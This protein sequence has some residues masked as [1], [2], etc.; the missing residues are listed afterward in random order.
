L[1]FPDA[2]IIIKG[3]LIKKLGR[4]EILSELGK[5]SM[6]IV[7]K[8]VDPLIDRTVAIKTINL[9][10]SGDEIVGFVERFNREAKS[11]GRLNHPNIVTIYDVGKTDDTAYI[12]ME[13]LE[14]QELKE[15]IASRQTL[16]PERI[17]EITAQIADGLAFAHDNG[18]VHRDIKPANIMILRNDVVKIMDFGIAM[19]S[20]GSQTIAGTI[21]G[22]PKY[23]SPEQVSGIAVDGRSDIFSLGA[24]LYEMLTG[25]SVFG[26]GS[27]N[28]LTS[29]MYQVVNEMPELPTKVNPA[30]PTA[31]DYIVSKAMAK[32]QED[33]Y[34]SAREM[35]DDLRSFMKLIIP[36]PLPSPVLSG[37]R[38]VANSQKN[39]DATLFLGPIRKTPVI[40]GW[41]L[42]KKR[43]SMGVAVIF[44]ATA[45]LF[46]YVSVPTIEL[47]P[48]AATKSKAAGGQSKARKNKEAATTKA[49]LDF[50]V[51]PWGEVFLDGKRLGVSP[52]L[53]KIKLTPGQHR[54]EIRNATFS[55]YR[56]T[57]KLEAGE[58]L[59]IRHK[60]N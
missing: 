40:P 30:I 48:P 10:L 6:G 35:A 18:V 55:P 7:Y 57:I 33:R 26:R 45:I 17:V 11:A 1:T 29:I 15:I 16:R 24:I 46:I 2:T 54:I 27:S 39:G 23:M 20:S 34:Q 43:I 42:Q 50:T 56:K 38:P 12:A 19:T 58:S 3:A 13:H 21:L 47:Q 28:S 37:K 32:K 31:F 25:I 8:A 22:S 44:L 9:N 4:Y 49:N 52:P 14:G 60:F 5:G 36:T 59:K 41:S 53:K 51:L